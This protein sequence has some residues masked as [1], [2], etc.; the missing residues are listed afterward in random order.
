MEIRQ[1]EPEER[2]VSLEGMYL[3]H[4][5]QELAKRMDRPIVV[6]NYVTDI[7]DVIAVEGIRGSP[8]ELKNPS[9]WRLFQELTAQA[10]AII[11]GASYMTEF[12]ENGES[13]QNVLTQFDKGSSFE[14][15]GDWRE[16]NGLKRNPDLVVVSR[17]LSFGI[18]KAISEG[19]RRILIFTTN[20]MEGSKNARELEKAGAT[21]IGAGKKGVDGAAMIERLGQEG[22]RVI[23]MI[24]GPRVLKILMDAEFKNQEGEVIRRGAL[25][26]LYITRVDR[27]IIDD[28]SG[29]VT[30]LEGITVDDLTFEG[31]GFRL[32]QRSTHDAIV[33]NDSYE[34]S[35]EFLVFERHDLASGSPERVDV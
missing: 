26:R 25:D 15:L 35:Q 23:K 1:I 11:T 17:S 12:E 9:D 7:N 13:V 18:P 14:D 8:E 19:G 3:S 10:D 20:S 34:T 31:G 28:L 30:V 21:V 5:L 4:R 32:I 29:A 16:Q 33:G 22:Y 27:K 6:A 2:R 24:T